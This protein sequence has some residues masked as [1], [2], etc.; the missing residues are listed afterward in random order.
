[1]AKVKAQKTV[2]FRRREP[3]KRPSIHAKSKASKMKHS[4]HYLKRYR[5]QGR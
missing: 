3:K 5:G 4:K 1:M 2:I